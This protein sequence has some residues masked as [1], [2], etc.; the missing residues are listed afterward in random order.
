MGNADLICTTAASLTEA[1]GVLS[2]KV[3]APLGARV[4]VSR[5]RFCREDRHLVLCRSR[6]RK[7]PPR[8]QAVRINC[9]A[10]VEQCGCIKLSHLHMTFFVPCSKPPSNKLGC[11][12]VS[13]IRLQYPCRKNTPQ[14]L[15]QS[16]SLENHTPRMKMC[17]VLSYRQVPKNTVTS[18]CCSCRHP[19][20]SNKHPPPHLPC[21][22]ITATSGGVRVEGLTITKHLGTKGP[23]FLGYR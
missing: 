3:R 2:H 11:P 18:N 12:R 4:S 1:T 19:N 23:H 15:N 14:E 13:L 16:I 6:L 21:T 17:S 22:S 10:E 5:T 9:L 8:K 7:L 20:H